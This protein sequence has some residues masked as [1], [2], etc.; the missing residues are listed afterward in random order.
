VVLTTCNLS[1]RHFSLLILLHQSCNTHDQVKALEYSR[2]DINEYHFW[3]EKLEASHPLATT[4]NSG[5]V[6]SEKDATRHVTDYYDILQN[7][8][9]YTFSG[10]RDGNSDTSTRPDGYGYGDDF[11]SVGDTRTQP[12]PRQ[13]R[14][15]YF[16]HP[17]I[18]QRVSILYN[19]TLFYFIFIWFIRRSINRIVPLS[20]IYDYSLDARWN[21]T[22]HRYGSYGEFIIIIKV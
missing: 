18:T 21:L 10:A 15:G 3:T 4:T 2:Y 22:R 11:L 6:I 12:E 9:E 17:Q 20:S 19:C 14:D 16:S 7:I 5:V 1:I 13:V 8:F